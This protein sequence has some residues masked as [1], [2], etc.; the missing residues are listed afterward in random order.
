M[1]TEPS[2][3]PS[4]SNLP[5]PSGSLPALPQLPGDPE[6]IHVD[7]SEVSATEC[8]FHCKLHSTHLQSSEPL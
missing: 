1:K 3:T 4:T 7:I 6:P 8:K 5:E 2:Q